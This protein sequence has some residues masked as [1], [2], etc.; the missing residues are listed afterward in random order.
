[1]KKALIP[2]A[3][4]LAFSMLITSVSA[5]VPEYYAARFYGHASGCCWVFTEEPGPD[6]PEP[7]ASGRGRFHIR[8][9]AIA[10][11]DTDYYWANSTDPNTRIWTRRTHMKVRWNSERLMVYMWPSGAVWSMFN[12]TISAIG[13]L[14][15]SGYYIDRCMF[16]HYIRGIAIVWFIEVEESEPISI[17]VIVLYRGTD[18][19]YT[20]VW[21]DR[22][23][24]ELPPGCVARR[25][26]RR[27][28]VWPI[29]WHLIL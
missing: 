26:I 7:T 25:I 12:D 4:L 2:I 29:P 16:R 23:V 17:A 6:P 24:E 19:F 13:N 15:F 8:G 22:E 1:M 11:E 3:A 9:F 20:F 10:R 18:H 27:V 14:T 21:T 28:T 5:P